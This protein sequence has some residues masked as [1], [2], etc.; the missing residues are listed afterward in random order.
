MYFVL[1]L[2]QSFSYYNSL[3]GGREEREKTERNA[4]SYILQ[5]TGGSCWR[6]RQHLA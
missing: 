1:S 6:N 2:S 4:R 3:L 5:E